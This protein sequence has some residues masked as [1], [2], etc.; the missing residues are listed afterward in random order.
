MDQKRNPRFCHAEKQVEMNS[1]SRK[2]RS[3]RN[4]NKSEKEEEEMRI[5]EE[6]EM[7]V[8][9]T[10]KKEENWRFAPQ[11][12]EKK[13]CEKVLTEGSARARA[14]AADVAP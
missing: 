10:R 7:R 6:G 1:A 11:V 12:K 14:I 4:E 9:V 2:I 3:R 13:N 8:K 5:K